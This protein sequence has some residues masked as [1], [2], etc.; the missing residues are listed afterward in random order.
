MTHY[1]EDFEEGNP[2]PMESVSHSRKP[3]TG[4]LEYLPVEDCSCHINPPCRNCT[5]NPLTCSVCGWE[6]EDV[7]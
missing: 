7:D 6:V 3:C 2:C 5:N 4:V 1:A